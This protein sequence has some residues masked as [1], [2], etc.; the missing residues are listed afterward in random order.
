M[1]PERWQQV[2]QLFHAVSTEHLLSVRR[3]LIESHPNP[4]KSHVL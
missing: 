1:K 4:P 2:D 3:F